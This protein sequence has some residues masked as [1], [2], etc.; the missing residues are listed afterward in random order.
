MREGGEEGAERE[1]GG[2]GEGEE[3]G[4]GQEGEGEASGPDPVKETSSSKK[5]SH[6]TREQQS[7]QKTMSCPCIILPGDFMRY[8]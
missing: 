3:E 5:V 2:E 1:R 8:V 7:L 4:E 6:H